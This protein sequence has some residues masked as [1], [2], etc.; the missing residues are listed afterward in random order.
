MIKNLKKFVVLFVATILFFNLLFLFKNETKYD[1]R[2]SGYGETNAQATLINTE[3]VNFTKREVEQLETVNGVPMYMPINGLT[4]S[5]GA[6]AGA[7][8][9]GFFDKYYENLIPNYKTY[10]STGR[11]KG[12]DNTY[13]PRVIEE[14]YVLM[15]TNIDDVG[16]SQYDCINGLKQYVI[17]K[18]YSINLTD[19]KK[20]NKVDE[21]MLSSSINNNNPSI[22]FC[23]KTDVYNFSL[24]SNSDTIYCTNLTA[25]GHIVVASG[26]YTIKYYNGDNLF[27]IDKYIKIA[28]GLTTQTNTYLRLDSNDWFNG[29]YSVS[30]N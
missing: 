24:S 18:G 15:R 7:I 23:A 8:V 30:I 11:Y 13:I 4:N 22:L 9:V 14:M 2:Y 5:C 27:R 25:G 16:V 10:I 21:A 26:L 17:N 6:I 12:N 19:I 20:S 3:T 1:F 29:A 28:T